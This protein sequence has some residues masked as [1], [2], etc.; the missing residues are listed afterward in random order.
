[1]S[2]RTTRDTQRNCVLKNKQTNKQ[3]KNQTINKLLRDDNKIK[4]NKV[5]KKTKHFRIGQSKQG[6]EP[7]KM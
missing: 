3:T 2:S 5:K 7:K 4:Y 1:V 6:K